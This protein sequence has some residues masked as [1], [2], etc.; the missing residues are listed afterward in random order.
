MGQENHLNKTVSLQIPNWNLG[1]VLSAM[2]TQGSFFFS[3]DS[4]LIPVDSILSVKATNERV[5]SVLKRILPKPLE[6]KSV[7]NHVVIFKPQKKAPTEVLISGYIRDSR[8]NKPL[9]NAT[10][11]NPQRNVMVASNDRGYYEMTVFGDDQ[12]LGLTVSKSGYRQEVVYVQPLL[13]SNLDFTLLTLEKPITGVEPKKLSY[14]DVNEHKIVQLIVPDRVI[15]NSNNLTLF[16]RVPVQFSVIPGI[17]TNGLLN[18]NSTNNFSLNLL[19]GYSQGT[20]GIEVGSLVNI[21]RRD[22][23][24]LQMAGIANVTGRFM[25]GVQ[26]AGMFNYTGLLFDGLQLAGMSNICMGDMNGVQL[27]GFCNILGGKMDGAQISGFANFTTEN[28]DGAQLSGFVNIAAK[29]VEVAQISGGVNYSQNIEGL[30]LAGLLNVATNQVSSSQ[31]SGFANYAK[32]SKGAQISGYVNVASELNSG[33]Q[34]ASS[35]NYTGNNEGVQLGLFNY[36]DT[37]SGLSIGLLSIVKRGYHVLD[38]STSENLTTSI[39]F[40][41][42][43]YRFYNIMGFGFTDKYVLPTYGIGTAPALGKKL[44]LNF[45]LTGSP[46]YEYENTQWG[47]ERY[48]LQFALALNYQP[49]KKFAIAIGPTLNYYRSR[50]DGESEVTSLSSY[51]FHQTTKGNYFEQMWIGGKLSIRMF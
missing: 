27:S 37:S 7:G 6:F 43:N 47:L 19:A 42:G 40:R 34:L 8:S 33:M 41:S 11:Y 14:P 5:G 16:E 30:Q 31:I 1:R 23:N 36:A 32:I 24:G 50:T 22:M 9:A 45:D 17:S 20:D 49:F 48:Y 39:S 4:E 15:E 38:I 29:D 2:E 12:K 13:K 18:A 10:L 3:Y 28:V 44:R 25:K 35:I 26:M 21:N 51:A 46:L